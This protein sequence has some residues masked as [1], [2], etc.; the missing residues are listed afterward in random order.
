MKVVK[1]MNAAHGKYKPINA[2]LVKM[3][4]SRP[5]V[6][7][8]RMELMRLSQ[9]NSRPD[10]FDNFQ[11]IA[12]QKSGY[13]ERFIQPELG[14]IPEKRTKTISTQYGPMDIELKPFVCTGFTKHQKKNLQ[15][16]GKLS[17]RKHGIIGPPIARDIEDVSLF[18]ERLQFVNCIEF[19]EV[20]KIKPK[21]CSASTK[22]LKLKPVNEQQEYLIKALQLIETVGGR[23]EIQKVSADEDNL[24][25]QRNM[26]IKY[27][28][29]RP[30][31]GYTRHKIDNVPSES[32][33]R[34]LQEDFDKRKTYTQAEYS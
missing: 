9:N 5:T 31:I 10:E 12:A 16:K 25:S 28:G 15:Q 20:A 7:S 32:T 26:D 24:I 4:H 19:A 17:P 30:S 21:S 29:D 1:A 8:Q 23:T 6:R 34:K 18:K 3:L 13:L 22:R 33:R 14:V 2:Q 11:V 27:I